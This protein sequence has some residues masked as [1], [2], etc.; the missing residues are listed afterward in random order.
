[1]IGVFNCRIN[2]IYEKVDRNPDSFL[3]SPHFTIYSVP[4]SPYTINHTPFTFV[5]SLEIFH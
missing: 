3:S 4:C 1:M 2:N 5:N